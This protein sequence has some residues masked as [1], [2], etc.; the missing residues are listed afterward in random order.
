MLQFNK[1]GFVVAGDTQ[2]IIAR[3]EGKKMVIMTKFLRLHIAAQLAELPP[4]EVPETFKLFAECVAEETEE[5]E[6]DN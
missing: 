5:F 4:E 1:N 2:L 6:N 3:V